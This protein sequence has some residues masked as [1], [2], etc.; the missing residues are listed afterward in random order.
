MGVPCKAQGGCDGSVLGPSSRTEH[1]AND[2]CS[3]G[4]RPDR[5]VVEECAN[6]VDSRVPTTVF[7]E[8]TEYTEALD[9]FAF[10][11][12]ETEL[13]GLA[14]IPNTMTTCASVESKIEGLSLNL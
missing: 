8:C 11:K 7:T 14:G 9:W 6:L 4:V 2:G 12:Y 3:S 5:D 1:C 13:S 10:C